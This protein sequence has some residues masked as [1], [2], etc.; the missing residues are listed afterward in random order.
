MSNGNVITT[1]SLSL[2]A[3]SVVRGLLALPLGDVCK[4]PRDVTFGHARSF[5][6]PTPA[7]KAAFQDLITRLTLEANTR[8]LLITGHTDSTGDAAINLALSSRRARATWAVLRG[9]TAEWEKLFIVDEGWLTPELIVMRDEVGLGGESDLSGFFGT[10]QHAKDVRRDMFTR[11]FAALLGGRAVPAHTP[12]TPDSFAYGK[13]QLLRGDPNNPSRDPTKP[14]IL[15]DFRP[16]RRSEF[17]SFKRG[18]PIVRDDYPKWAGSCTL[19][20]PVR[21][22]VAIAPVETV[23]KD[24]VVE[25]DITVSPDVPP[26]SNK[27]AISLRLSTTSGTG[28][29]VFAD[30]NSNV[31]TIRGSR[32]VK[33]RGVNVSSVTDNVRLTASVIGQPAGAPAQEDF[34]VVDNIFIHL[35]FEVFKLTPPSV[36]VPLPQGVTVDLMAEGASGAPVIASRPTDASGRVRFNLTDLNASGRPDPDIFFVART[37]RRN[38]AGHTLPKEW[39]TKGW[40]AADNTTPGLQP[41]FSGPA[42]GTPSAPIV[43]RVGLDFHAQLKYHVDAGARVG[44]DDPAPIGIFVE[45]M[46]EEIGPD[47]ALLDL[48]TTAGGKIDGVSFEAEAGRTFYLR[49]IFQIEDLP[50][51]LKAARFTRVPGVLP[52]IDIV[53]PAGTPM[54]WDSND[55]DADKKEFKDNRNTS[56]GT[57]AAPENFLC[58]LD[59]RNVA[60]YLLK[61][62]RELNLFLSKMTQGDWKGVEVAV[63]PTAP[64]R[65]FSWPVNRIQLGFPDD[66]WSRETITHEMG[67]QVMWEVVNFRSVG[68]FY[69]GSLGQ[70]QL[71]HQENLMANSEQALIEGWAEFIEA[72]FQSTATPGVSPFPASPPY[73]VLSLVSPPSIPFTTPPTVPGGLG[74]PPLNRGENVEGAL[75][76]GLWAIFDNHVAALPGPLTALVPETA[77]GEVAVTAPWILTRDIQLRFLSQI[78]RPLKALRPLNNPNSTLLFAEIRNKNSSAPNDTWHLLLPELQAFNMAMLL[79]TTTKIEPHWGP[80]TGGQPI[81]LS[82]KITGANFIARTT[83]QTGAAA[84]VVLETTVTFDGAL[85]PGVT[86][87]SQSSLQIVPPPHAVGTIDVVVTTPGGTTTPPLK[88]TYINDT[89]TVIDIAVA[90]PAGALDPRVISTNGRDAFEILGKGF[91]PGAIVEVAGAPVDPADVTIPQPDLIRVAKTAPQA[92]GV[93]DV[94][95]KNPDAADS[96]L[97]GR[98]RYADPPQVRNMLKPVSRSGPVNQSND[99]TVEGFNIAPNATVTD[100]TQSLPLKRTPSSG[101]PTEVEFSLPPGPPGLVILELQNPSDG[102][103]TQFEFNREDVGP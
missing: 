72:I 30:N 62:L 37:N 81:N 21:T 26:L 29:A 28:S 2:L 57:V 47:R 49:V 12:A 69:E 45:L 41:A 88:F 31:L 82:V 19:T 97:S 59:D 27:A 86:V 95:V 78:W 56:I 73:R 6:E 17:F 96:I 89:L 3:G 68:I 76:N 15:G 85:V 20:P 11:Y 58:T 4:V 24:A 98:L 102:L 16:N 74:P 18:V 52:G 99:I 70:L 60:L 38:H 87:A 54:F 92:A 100:G 91:L 67:H 84:P 23:R 1:A 80:V 55:S 7:N 66:R 5:I 44:N 71:N 53:T 75:A 25:F 14:E 94:R 13:E 40:M 35:Q 51:G 93:V 39:S 46:Q 42:L 79:P 77:D 48:Q 103:S 64:V 34:T 61:S 65:A 8:L 32:K 10:S 36:F 50:N 83:A 22:T 63:T 43:F 90:G 33:V 101:G 9:D